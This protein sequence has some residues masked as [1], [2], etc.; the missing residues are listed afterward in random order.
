MRFAERSRASGYQR[1]LTK[2]RRQTPGQALTILLQ[3]DANTRGPPVATVPA[4]SWFVRMQN[5][6][7]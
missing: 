1:P 2:S 7:R 3:L 6:N 5:T 4:C